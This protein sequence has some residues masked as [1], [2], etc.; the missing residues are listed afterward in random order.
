LLWK[1][2]TLV[3]QDHPLSSAFDSRENH[4]LAVSVEDCY[5]IISSRL[6]LAKS[7]NDYYFYYMY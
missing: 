7:A 4:D 1:N 5:S 6:W 2:R 3:K